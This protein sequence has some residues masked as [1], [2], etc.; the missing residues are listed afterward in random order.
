MSLTLRL[1]QASWRGFA[2]CSRSNFQTHE[3]LART[4]SVSTKLKSSPQDERR[5]PRSQVTRNDFKSVRTPTESGGR[6]P[7]RKTGRSRKRRGA[8][9]TPPRQ[10][11]LPELGLTSKQ[12]AALANVSIERVLGCAKELDDTVRNSS[13]VLSPALVDLVTEELRLNIQFRPQTFPFLSQNKVD[14]ASLEQRMPVVTVMGHVDHGKTSLLDA[15]RK[16]DVAKHEVGG[17]T[18]SVA[19][20]QVP[21]DVKSNENKDT[22]FA[23][24][25]DT[26]GHAAFKSMRANGTVATDIVI[27]VVAADDGVMPQS[28]EAGNLACA[29][30]VPVI[31]AVNKCDM[32]GA[33]PERVR[34]QLLEVLGINTEQ[35]GGDVQCVDISAK[36]GAN[37]PQLL[38]AVSLQAEMLDLQSDP[39]A[40]AAGICL[41]SRLDRALGSIATV[42][43]RSGTLRS[44]DQVVFQ[45][46]KSLRGDLFGRVR[47]LID[48]N[49]DRLHEVKPGVAAGLIGLRDPIPP[50]SE[51]CVE[52]SEKAARA[53]SQ[54]MITRNVEAVLTIEQANSLCAEREANATADDKT[55]RVLTSNSSATGVS[56]SE[57]GMDEN[58]EIRTIAILV[59]GDVKGSADAVAQCVQAMGTAQYPIRILDAGVGD[60]TDMDIKIAAAPRHAKGNTEEPIIIAFNVRVRESEKRTARRAGVTVLSHNLI[61]HLE[62]ELK[63]VL[64]KIHDERKV[65]EECVGK[66]SVVRVFDDGKIAGCSVDDGELSV[67]DSANVLRLPDSKTGEANREVVF[68][69]TVDSIKQFAKTVRAVKKGSACGIGL[70]G[71]SSFQSGDIVESVQTTQRAAS[72]K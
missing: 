44:G 29:A 43:V 48:K 3:C 24:F 49:G 60:V 56:E 36:T 65:V 19:A 42:V 64:E 10:L 57:S 35:L 61:Y 70:E 47:D 40:R 25:I 33:D 22:Q 67:G 13:A 18:Q 63:A 14:G 6:T 8:R 32:P 20:F 53:K 69:G 62:D 15:L 30:N 7:S 16:S 66:A 59:R 58:A 12:L 31:V 45:S 71:W 41:E 28:I 11:V 9:P 68:S 72:P 1:A 23:T 26:P 51:F 21:I 17:I 39:S 38:E 52:V 46:P 34:Y 2:R 50:G 55:P 37:L 5:L 54:E 27:L 4:L